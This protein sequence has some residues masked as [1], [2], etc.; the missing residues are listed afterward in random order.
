MEVSRRENE[1]RFALH[2]EPRLARRLGRALC[3]RDVR[4]PSVEV[5]FHTKVNCGTSIQVSCEVCQVQFDR[6]LRSGVLKRNAVS[7]TRVSTALKDDS[8]LMP[9]MRVI[10][11]WMHS[12]AI[13][14][15]RRTPIVTE[16]NIQSTD[17]PRAI[18]KCPIR[19]TCV[20]RNRQPG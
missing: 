8:E 13:K 3:G 20:R 16:I 19:D 1:Q 17:Y 18:F 7:G 6:D 4:G 11:E 2:W 10:E 9:P 5:V 14:Q 15:Y 12:H